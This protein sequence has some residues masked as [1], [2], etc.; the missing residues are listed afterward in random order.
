METAGDV[1]PFEAPSGD[2]KTR[3]LTPWKSCRLYDSS[4]QA[5]LTLSFRNH[6]KG[7]ALKGGARDT[8]TTLL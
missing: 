7:E 6:R 2:P 8:R 3:A 4:P 1:D 5:L